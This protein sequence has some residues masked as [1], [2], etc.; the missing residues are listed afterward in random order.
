MNLIADVFNSSLFTT[1]SLTAAVNDQPYLPQFLG[2]LGLF[3]EKGVETTSVLIERK[4]ESLALVQSS[5]RGAP[6]VPTPVDKRDAVDLQAPRLLQPGA[7]M[8]DSIQNVR[9]FG[10]PD[11][12]EGVETK[13]DEVLAAQA[14]N[15]DLTLE[16]HRLG[17]VQGYVLDADGSV[18]FDLYS[19]FGITAPAQVDF[20]LDQPDAGIRKS[21]NGV[22]RTVNEALG[23]LR[24]TVSGF[25]ALCG[26]EFF[27]EFTNHDEVIKTYLNQQAAND[28][29]EADTL[30]AVVFGG[31]VWVNYQGY[32]QVRIQDEEFRML[33]IG[34]PDLFQTVFT[35][36]DYMEAVNTIGLPRYSKAEMMKFD[37]GIELETQSNPVTFCT[38]PG[39]LIGGRAA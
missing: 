8:A 14:R 34:V 39:A 13:R 17:A 26:D 16:Y 25:V 20:K 3:A 7:L 12:L 24:A 10:S 2:E 5:A 21:I 23:A 37:R 1:M 35:P 11:Q 4:G 36:A 15:L 31:V 6:G 32:G 38:R 28:L 19:K 9:R 29:R 22:K 30:D 27:D 18:I 33:P